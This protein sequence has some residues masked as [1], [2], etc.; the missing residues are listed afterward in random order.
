MKYTKNSF[1][2]SLTDSNLENQLRCATS[3]KDIN[4]E[5]LSEKKEEHISH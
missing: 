3:N 2:A 5:K 1:R 4:L